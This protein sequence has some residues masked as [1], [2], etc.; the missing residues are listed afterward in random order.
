MKNEEWVGNQDQ[1]EHE[2]TLALADVYHSTLKM[3]RTEESPTPPYSLD[4]FLSL[5]KFTWGFV[6][7]HKHYTFTFEF[8]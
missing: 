5:L 2:Q 8:V 6:L 3:P 4:G 7:F 1:I